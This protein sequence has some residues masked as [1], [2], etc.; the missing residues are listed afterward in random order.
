MLK[1]LAVYPKGLWLAQIAEQWRAQHIH[2]HWAGTTASVAMVASNISGIPWSFTC[3][4]WDIVENNLL[5]LKV[6]AATLARFI[7]QKGLDMA[8]SMGVKGLE[9]KARVIHMG[10]ELPELPSRAGAKNRPPIIICPANLLPVKGH[11]YLIEAVALLKER[12]VQ[13]CLWI[14]GQGELRECLEK[15]VMQ[16]GVSC[17]VRFLGQLSHLSILHHYA[18]G[19]V[20]ALVLAS[21]DLG[22]NEHEGIPVALIE[23]MSY[24]V[25]V[26]ATAA[27]GVP[28]LLYGGAGLV[29]PPQ[30]PQSLADAIQS[31]ISDHGLREQLGRAGRN[32]VEQEFAVENTVNEMVAMFG[33]GPA[34]P[35]EA[36]GAYPAVQPSVQ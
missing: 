13:I 8:T 35:K 19:D 10:V 11:K 23:A 2:A 31:L 25:P 3:H 16:R 18:Q 29:V 22:N 20:D 15:Q 30:E 14:A 6:R 24:G 7:N 26:V 1:N 36:G 9:R 27:G 4:R 33:M 5:C 32:R 17:Q 34:L 12:G 21:V 28:E